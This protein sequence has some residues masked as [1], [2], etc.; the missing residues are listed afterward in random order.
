MI[1]RQLSIPISFILLFLL[2]CLLSQAQARI[3]RRQHGERHRIHSLDAISLNP[4]IP[5][6][7]FF[8][9]MY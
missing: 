8:E 3:H 6:R 5:P 4:D 7:Q 9:G 2:G 1:M